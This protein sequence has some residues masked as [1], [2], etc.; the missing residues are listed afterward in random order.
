MCIRDSL[1]PG[2]YIFKVKARSNNGLITEESSIHF[3][4]KYPFW[5]SKYAIL[6]YIGIIVAFVINS[7]NKVKKL[8]NLVELRTKE[9]SE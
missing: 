5:A 6:L 3:Y 9:L 7:I 1:S 2:D 8:D 4:I